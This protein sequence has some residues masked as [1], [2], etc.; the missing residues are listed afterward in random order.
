MVPIILRLG[1]LAQKSETHVNNKTMISFKNS[2]LI[3]YEGILFCDYTKTNKILMNKAILTTLVR[4]ALI[5]LFIDVQLSIFF[6]SG[7]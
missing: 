1:A 2:I 4:I 7:L 6:E 5:F 3:E